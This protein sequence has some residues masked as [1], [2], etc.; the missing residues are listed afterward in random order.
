MQ[1]S[2]QRRRG[3]M[4]RLGSDKDR[5]KYVESDAKLKLKIIF[6]IM[7]SFGSHIL[8]LNMCAHFISW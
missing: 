2:T 8:Q 7:C 5:S 6:H 1:A 4:E 3:D